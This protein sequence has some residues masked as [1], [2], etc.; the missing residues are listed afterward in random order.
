LEPIRKSTVCWKSSAKRLEPEGRFWVTISDVQPAAK[1]GRKVS[2]VVS[3]FLDSNESEEHD[4][5]RKRAYRRDRANNS[6][7]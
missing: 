1:S 7:D 2:K 4:L 5:E 3:R 6:G